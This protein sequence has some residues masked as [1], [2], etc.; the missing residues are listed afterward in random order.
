MQKG[1]KGF[2]CN[3]AQRAVE[4]GIEGGQAA[5]IAPMLVQK[6]HPE[7]GL[8]GAAYRRQIVRGE[9]TLEAERKERVQV[10]ERE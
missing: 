5:L 9:A 8:V 2:E 4:R 3:N 7:L 1:G 6:L 10:P